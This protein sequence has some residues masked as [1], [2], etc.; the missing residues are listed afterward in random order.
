M[1]K[2]IEKK[3]GWRSA[4]TKKALPWWLGALLAAF[5]V[6]LIARPD[7]KTLRVD[8]DALTIST[9]TSGEFNDYIRLSGRVQPM[10]TI[11]LSPQEGGIVE[12]I[13]IEEGSPSRPA[14]P[15]WC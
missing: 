8:K 9:A 3:T 1:D 10:T 6:Y 13:L 15:S 7:N 12:Q 14:T 4:F 5:I 11:Q 2:I